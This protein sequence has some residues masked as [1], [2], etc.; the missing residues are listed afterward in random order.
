[1]F[2]HTLQFPGFPRHLVA[3]QL[4]LSL[5][6]RNCRCGHHLDVFGH[7]QAACARARVLSRRGYALESVMARVCREAGGRVTTNVAV[8]DLDLEIADRADA[9][10][11]DGLPL[12][13]G[14]QLAIDATIVS[15]LRGDGSAGVALTAARRRKEHKYPELVGPR[16]RARLGCGR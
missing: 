5:T 10:R 14:A 8:R 9:R 3:Q 11:V 2:P 13:G 6:A 15:A 16:S 7:H 1:M 12:F 4:P